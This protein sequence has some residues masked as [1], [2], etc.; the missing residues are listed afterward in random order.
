MI[1]QDDNEVPKLPKDINEKISHEDKAQQKYYLSLF[2]CKMSTGL[3]AAYIYTILSITINI[4]NRVIF[5][6]YEFNFEYTLLFF[7]EIV[8]T[9]FYLILAWKSNLFKEKAGELSFKD[10]WKLKFKYIGYSLFF[11]LKTLF[12]FL[13]YQ[14]VKNIPMYVNLRKLVTPM[15]FIYQFFFKKLK[16]DKIK[17]I[18]V[19]LFT[20]GAILSGI[21]DY[22]TDYIGYLIVFFENV[23][24]VINLEVSE[25]FKGNNGVSNL[26]L[27]AYK[28]FVLPPILLLGMLASGEFGELYHYFKEE[29]EFSY[30]WLFFDIFIICSIIFIYTMS[31]FISSEKIKSLLTQLLSDIKYIFIALL[32]YF[33]LKTFKFNWKNILALIIS[34]SGAIIITISSMYDNIKLKKKGVSEL[35]DEQ[36]IEIS[37]IDNTGLDDKVKNIEK[38]EETDT[39][40]NKDKIENEESKKNTNNTNILKNKNNN[41]ESLIVSGDAANIEQK[42]EGYLA[43]ENSQDSNSKNINESNNKDINND[44]NNESKNDL[45]NNNINNL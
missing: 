8:C 1:K 19:V 14:V 21:D 29:H 38:S 12:A 30:F 45:N 7:Q 3:M 35:T 28:S 33:I 32:S 20:I 6:K 13:A 39:S 27:L 41:N 31:F 37:N 15:A 18:V 36:N 22:T 5:L 40:T 44:L 11:L 23:M 9:V 43:S 17:I 10:F 26:K 42:N 25:N 24:S 4:V 34:T 16:I 2:C